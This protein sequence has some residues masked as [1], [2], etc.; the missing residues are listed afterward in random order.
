[1]AGYSST[2]LLKKLGVKPQSRVA[3]LGEEIDWLVDQLPADVKTVSHLR[4]RGADV[5]VLFCREMRTLKKRL[6][7]CAAAIAPDGALWVAWPRKAAGH[8]SD[9]GDN[10]VRAE[11]LP[12]GLVDVKVAALSEDWSGIKFVWRKELRRSSL[13]SQ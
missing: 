9:L 1:M 2:P 3:V 8:V 10:A 6:A 13:A 7:A 4:A 5:V 12:T 11:C